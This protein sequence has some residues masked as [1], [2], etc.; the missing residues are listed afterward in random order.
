MGLPPE[1]TANVPTQWLI[2]A[3]MVVGNLIIASMFYPKFEQLTRQPD[4]SWRDRI[5]AW[6][7]VALLCVLGAATIIISIQILF[8][9]DKTSDQP[10]IQPKTFS[11][12]QSSFTTN[13]PHL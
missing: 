4:S 8:P 1:I 2:I 3:S 12:A 9:G 10:S 11:I 13:L 6:M 7:I 5:I